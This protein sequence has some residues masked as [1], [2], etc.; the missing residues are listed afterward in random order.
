MVKEKEYFPC[1]MIILNSSLPKGI[2]YV[3]TKNLDGETN[4]KHKQ[5]NKDLAKLSVTVKD[6][7]S[8][9]K[10][11]ELECEKENDSIYTF[12]GN[13]KFSDRELLVPIDVDQVLLRGSSLRNTE[14]VY[15][16]AVYTGHDSKVMMNSLKSKPKFSKIE[17]STNKYILLSIIIQFAVC[18]FSGAYTSIWQNL[19]GVQ[20][21]YYYLDLRPDPESQGFDEF[22]HNLFIQIV[23]N[24]GKWF[25]IMMNFV[26]ISLLV[27]LE[28]V[29][30]AQGIF[31]EKDWMLYDEEK[32]IPAK[33]QSSNLNEEL[34]MVHYIFSDKTGTLTKNIMD[35][36]K[37]SAG[38]K[39][40]G[41]DLEVMYPGKYE[42]GLTNVSFTS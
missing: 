27:S 34:G 17:K 42:K 2:C 5:A 30:F 16:I 29:K 9:F 40:Y 13:L 18:F 28:M 39:S 38:P 3:E 35:F 19:D 1:D 8:N 15:G 23:V 14:W 21:N 33:V 36:K 41:D 7:L 31:I 11:A 10:T 6:I 37:F 4:L 12:Q 20:E 32:D 22:D 25:L 26:S 24:F